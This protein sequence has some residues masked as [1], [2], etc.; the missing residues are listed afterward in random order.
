MQSNLSPPIEIL[1][2]FLIPG[3]MQ[4]KQESQIKE[5]FKFN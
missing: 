1:D 2:A 3:K 5:K 4:F